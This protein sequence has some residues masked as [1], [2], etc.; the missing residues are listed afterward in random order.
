MSITRYARS[1]IGTCV[2][3]LTVLTLGS[4]VPASAAVAAYDGWWTIAPGQTAELTQ[5]A[6]TK[7]PDLYAWNGAES[8]LLLAKKKDTVSLS[9]APSTG[10]GFDLLV[11]DSP[12]LSLVG[13][14]FKLYFERNPRRDDVAKDL[15]SLFVLAD[16]NS[17]SFGHNR[18]SLRDAPAVQAGLLTPAPAASAPLPGALWL[19]AAGVLAIVGLR[20]KS[21]QN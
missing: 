15:N 11:N 20:L 4:G 9:L 10:G 13:S 16:D 21:T 7:S 2:I 19:L 1:A 3:A 6:K 8:V 14:A 18:K 17:F 5:F 12:A